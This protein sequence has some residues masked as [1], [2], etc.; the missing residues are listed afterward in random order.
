MQK[1]AYLFTLKVINGDVNN[2]KIC[3]FLKIKDANNKG[4][5]YKAGV[6]FIRR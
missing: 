4:L 6:E 5:G 1:T 2:M 3:H